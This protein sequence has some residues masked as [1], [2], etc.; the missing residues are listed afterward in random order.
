M[1]QPASR[2]EYPRACPSTIRFA[3]LYA[4]RAPRD[5]V[6]TA[7]EVQQ[8]GRAFEHDPGGR[9]HCVRRDHGACDLQRPRPMVD[10]QPVRV[11]PVSLVVQAV[12]LCEEVLNGTGGR[13]KRGAGGS[14]NSRELRRLSPSTGTLVSK[15]VRTT[16]ERHVSRIVGQIE[17]RPC[18]DHS[19]PASGVQTEEVDARPVAHSDV[20]SDIEFSES[21]HPWQRGRRPKTNVRHV[22]RHDGNHAAP[23]TR[24][25]SKAGGTKRRR[26]DALTRQ[27][28]KST[29]C[30]DWVI[31]HGARGIGHGR[32][33]VF[34]TM[35]RSKAIAQ[36]RSLTVPPPRHGRRK[37][38]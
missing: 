18:G 21:R 10:V 16:F 9:R 25:R 37:T 33:A 17:P 34:S 31:S 14:I 6:L 35:E 29:S 4:H 7:S 1:D 19:Q 26:S 23:S 15:P 27:W 32:W 22:E 5:H 2:F 24:S 8:R 36:A 12:S 3:R 13:N 28:A 11:A 20:G 30:Q 38:Q